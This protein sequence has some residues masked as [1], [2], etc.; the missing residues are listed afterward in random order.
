MRYF[1]LKLIKIDAY[2]GRP[3]RFVELRSLKISDD[4]DHPRRF[5]Q[6]CKCY[7]EMWFANDKAFLII[8]KDSGIRVSCSNS[9]LTFDD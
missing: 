6:R 1:S 2:Q 9:T 3:K 4:L 7:P 8:S 5:D